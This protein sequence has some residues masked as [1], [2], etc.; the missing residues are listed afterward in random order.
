MGTKLSVDM[1]K[2]LRLLREDEEFRLAVMGLLGIMDIQSGIKQLVSAIARL[3][4]SQGK[5][6]NAMQGMTKGEERITEMLGKVT[7][8]LAKIDEAIMNLAETLGR[9]IDMVE[10]IVK[11]QEG[12][13]EA[14]KQLVEAQRNTWE[15]VGQVRS[16]EGEVLSLLRQ[17]IESQGRL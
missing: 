11:A 1:D 16:D 7:D 6:V 8:T 17:S 2:L 9:D 5:S 12:L 10:R 15:V 4:E 14:V 3:A 13:G